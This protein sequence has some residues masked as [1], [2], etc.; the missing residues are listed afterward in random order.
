MRLKRTHRRGGGLCRTLADSGTMPPTRNLRTA[1]Y[2]ESA[3]RTLGEAVA[4]ARRRAGFRW[5]TDLARAH[6]EVS[7]SSLKLIEQA[8]PLVG[9]TA[10]QA[11]GGA[12][13]EHF[14]EAWDKDTPR[15][16]LEGGRIPD[17]DAAP[18]S[19]DLGPSIDRDVDPLEDVDDDALLA[20][21]T[22]RSRLG[23]D[24]HLEALG[25]LFARDR[26]S[27]E[28]FA[29]G[30]VVNRK[31]RQAREAADREAG[32]LMQSLTERVRSDLSG[33]N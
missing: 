4:D 20:I 25:T 17:L 32:N 5:R 31:V 12:L 2:S 6:P 16:I 21:V 22:D 15:A 14:P 18:I 13:G 27:K 24:E 26:L 30:L 8:K 10:L 7:V 9:I 33:S 23:T 11:V 19:A 29:Y 28:A 3:R 1:D